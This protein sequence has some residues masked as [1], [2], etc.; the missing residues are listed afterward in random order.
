MVIPANFPLANVWALKHLLAEHNDAFCC[1][2]LM[3]IDCC[4]GP[5]ECAESCDDDRNNS[6]A[7]GAGL[8]YGFDDRDRDEESGADK[9]ETEPWAT[10]EELM[11]AFFVEE[12]R[13]RAVEQCRFLRG[14]GG[15]PASNV[16]VSGHI[17]A[18]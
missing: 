9:A 15:N 18:S 14:G 8:M 16:V 6:S 10:T 5:G 3:L 1:W 13:E 7:V 11:S 4:E 12:R 17:D 2:S